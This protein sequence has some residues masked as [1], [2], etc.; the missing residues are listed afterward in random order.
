M[1]GRRQPGQAWRGKRPGSPWRNLGI[2]VMTV[3]AVCLTGFA[4]VTA[5]LAIEEAAGAILA[6]LV[7]GL[8]ITVF[9]L[10]QRH[11]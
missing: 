10:L 8:L 6:G 7:A 4:M 9:L 2:W 11:R 1:D 3:M 5:G